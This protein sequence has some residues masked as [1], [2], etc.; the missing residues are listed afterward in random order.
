MTV[1]AGN[2]VFNANPFYVGGNMSGTLTTVDGSIQFLNG[3]DFY[4]GGVMS[5]TI[6]ANFVAAE[7]K[8]QFIDSAFYVQSFVGGTIVADEN[9]EFEVGTSAFEVDFFDG[10]IESLTADVEF[11]TSTYN[12]GEM[13]ADGLIQANQDVSFD[14]ATLLFDTF[15]GTIKAFNVDVTFDFS[16][17]TVYGGF[18]GTIMAEGGGNVNFDASAFNVYGSDGFTGTIS[19]FNNV[20][21]DT[22]PLAVSY[23]FDG[24]I[25]ADELNIDFTDSA[26]DV[27]GDFTGA[28]E[29]EEGVVTFDTSPITVGDDFGGTITAHS[30]LTFNGSNIDV[31]EDFSGTF[32]SINDDVVFNNDT[33]FTVGEDFSGLISAGDEIKFDDGTGIDIEGDFDGTWNA[34]GSINFDPATF[35]CRDFDGIWTTT[36]VDTIIFDGSDFTVDTFGGSWL[37]DAIIFQN[38]STFTVNFEMDGMIESDVNNIEFND[39]DVL[40]GN[41]S[42]DMIAEVNFEFDG[43]GVHNTFT[44]GAFSGTIDAETGMVDFDDATIDLGDF[45]GGDF[46]GTILAA[47][48]MK[49]TDGS[50]AAD[51][52]DG[53]FTTTSGV[54]E[55]DPFPVT[56][57]ASG[58]GGSIQGAG[59]TFDS[60]DLTV[61][62]DFSGQLYAGG[63]SIVFDGSN[64]SITGVFSGLFDAQAGAIDIDGTS[65][66]AVYVGGA[67]TGDWWA[68]TDINV[69][70][71]NFTIDG[72]F[73]GALEA[74]GDIDPVFYLDSLGTND[75]DMI[76]DADGDNV[77]DLVGTLYAN[78]SFSND[79]EF[80]GASVPMSFY[81]DGNFYGD[82]DASLAASGGGTGFAGTIDIEGN[83]G[84][85]LDPAENGGSLTSAAG[86]NTFTVGVPGGGGYVMDNGDGAG[87]FEIDVAD[88]VQH[89]EVY[90]M[91]PGVNANE[92][93]FVRAANWQTF[94]VR[95]GGIGNYVDILA[96]S[97]PGTGYIYN[98][99]IEGPHVDTH[100]APGGGTHDTVRAQ[101]GF[102]G[103]W[104][105][106][107]SLVVDR[108]GYRFNVELGDSGT[109]DGYIDI[110]TGKK[111]DGSVKVWYFDSDFG[112]NT[113]TE[114]TTIEWN[115]GDR[116]DL[117]VKASSD[118][119]AGFPSIGLISAL[120]PPKGGHCGAPG[121]DSYA[122]GF[123]NI[124]VQRVDVERIDL[125]GSARDIR[126]YDAS[127]NY[128]TIGHSNAFNENY[129]DDPVG[130]IRN[131]KVKNGD[132]GHNGESPVGSVEILGNLTSK[133]Q[134]DNIYGTID[135]GGSAKR[136]VA[137]Y[138]FMADTTVG[139]NLNKLEAQ[140][141]EFDADV[142]VYGNFDH[143]KAK[144]ATTLWNDILVDGKLKRVTMPKADFSY[145][146]VECSRLQHHFNV[147]GGKSDRDVTSFYHRTEAFY[148]GSVTEYN[149]HLRV[150][151]IVPSSRI[152]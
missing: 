76:A 123:N 143:L 126:F 125:S 63:G 88:D 122:A 102:P 97:E 22:S 47:T 133:M 30:T 31:D 24:T 19:G 135:I 33:Q 111:R 146:Y 113:I 16:P 42:G 11:N 59:V 3:S 6:D 26:I 29:A 147:L 138:D 139:E 114:I 57:G 142:T 43:Q 72:E 40:I 148:Y 130:N 131:L 116:P 70:G 85:H 120:H 80:S 140:K 109:N 46:P 136:I 101:R 35:H 55:F 36:G 45:T 128:V 107:Q 4:V 68:F 56:V 100:P 7:G 115:E 65:A 49:F 104:E 32:E 17:I 121:S 105:I 54:I 81:I 60:S 18:G 141:G 73:D 21:F 95:C 14:T 112:V 78:G 12:F 69:D 62:G 58:F 48:G 84:G 93:V 15:D 61:L 129:W 53:I 110:K 25:F 39:S 79:A 137:K 98:L 1:G 119:D 2:F 124:K 67:F 150:W 144:K 34:G 38:G 71:G 28:I 5:G 99:R 106:S 118:L 51:P 23:D 37:S 74:N 13:G 86:L 27:G 92:T 41:L 50:L 134:A 117:Y 145:G 151:D 152:K 90:G 44:L 64:I 149:A 75:G 52:F 9:V 132:I 87:T 82:F 127:V 20:S 10:T 94:I 96:G 91:G 108:D 66:N 83:F 89:F 77:G 8:V 103:K